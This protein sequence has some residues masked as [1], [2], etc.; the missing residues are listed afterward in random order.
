MQ[1]V[2]LN[3]DGY[4]WNLDTHPRLA[5]QWKA[6]RLPEGAKEDKERTNDTGAAV[7]ITFDSKDWLGRPRSIKYTYS[8]TLPVG[9]TAKYGPLRVLVVSS[10]AD[11]LGEWLRVERDVEADYKR[12]FGK[13]EAPRPGFIMLWSD[14]DNT[15]GL[16][17]VY[18]DDIEMRAGRR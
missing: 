7:Y 6:K 2:R 8:S 13:D 14:S 11:G 4:D 17:D 10:A 5:W 18:F 3:G 12:L 16:A 1:V 9:T 15:H